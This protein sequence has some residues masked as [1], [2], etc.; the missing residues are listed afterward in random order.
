VSLLRL[1][2]TMD[3]I[4]VHLARTDASNPSV[5][6][7]ISVLREHDP[8]QFRLSIGVE[9]TKLNP[10]RRSREQGEVNAVSVP[11]GAM[12]MRETLAKRTRAIGHGETPNP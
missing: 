4:S 6:E 8:F 1:I 9:K 10:L 5:K 12:R 2:A 11:G 7:L 3:A